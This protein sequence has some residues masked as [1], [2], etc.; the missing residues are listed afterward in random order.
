MNTR[1]YNISFFAIFLIISLFFSSVGIYF[2]RS[3]KDIDADGEKIGRQ[4]IVIDAG[5]GGEDGGAS[6]YGDVPEKELNL[7]IS[8]TLCDMLRFSGVDVI[9]TREEDVLLYDKN[10]DYHGKKKSQDLAKR[11]EIA[12]SVDNA[13]LISIHMNAF[14]E[15]KYKGLQVYFSPNNESSYK[16]ASLIQNETRIKLMPDNSRKV[17]RANSSIYLLNRYM[18]TGILIECGFLSNPEEYA[19]LCTE[20]Y[21]SELSLVFMGAIS[22]YLTNDE[23]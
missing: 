17:K 16:L 7:M 2:S 19:R 1:S 5:H 8:K 22:R 13:I 23:R 3:A 21:R 14:P 11:L 6:V 15:A 18:G 20:E 12:N 9:M 4:T 10:S